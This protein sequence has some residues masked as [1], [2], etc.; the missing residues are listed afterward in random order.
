M[1]FICQT[2]ERGVCVTSHKM[3]LSIMTFTFVPMSYHKR[4]TDVFIYTP[5]VNSVPNM[6][7]LGQK[8]KKKESR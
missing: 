7:T 2:N 6:N 5:H 4:E 1:N 3:I 8:M